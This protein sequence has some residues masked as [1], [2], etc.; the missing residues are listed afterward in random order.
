L[1]DALS[2]FSAWKNK[3]NK[4]YTELLL[5]ILD[6]FLLGFPFGPEYW[7]VNGYKTIR[8]HI[9]VDSIFERDV[10]LRVMVLLEVTGVIKFPVEK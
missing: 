5:C 6:A 8:P 7:S 10:N 1:K 2:L 9:P 3:P 4:L